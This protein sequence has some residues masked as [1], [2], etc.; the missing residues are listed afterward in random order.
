MPQR[1]FFLAAP[2]FGGEFQNEKELSLTKVC[3]N[4]LPPRNLLNQQKIDAYGLIVFLHKGDFFSP[5]GHQRLLRVKLYSAQKFMTGYNIIHI[6][7]CVSVSNIV[8][9]TNVNTSIAW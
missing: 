8:G 9:E 6:V 2:E 1:L 7:T 5:F 4:I 3:K